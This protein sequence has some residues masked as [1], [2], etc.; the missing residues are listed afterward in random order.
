MYVE[1]PKHKILMVKPVSYDLLVISK[2]NTME[3]TNLN[4]SLAFRDEWGENK[5]YLKKIKLPIVN[6][7]FYHYLLILL[8]PYIWF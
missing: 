1:P 5:N 3:V 6:M 4:L 7:H 2:I 8:L